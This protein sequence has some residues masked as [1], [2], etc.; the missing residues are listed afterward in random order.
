MATAKPV[1]PRIWKL[2]PAR[3]A[4][5]IVGRGRASGWWFNRAV[6]V[7]A[8]LL[9]LGGSRCDD[10]PSEIG[11]L[12]SQIRKLR[13]WRRNS[14]SASS[15]AATA[16]STGSATG[17]PRSANPDSNNDARSTGCRRVSRRTMSTSRSRQA[18]RR[19]E[20]TRRRATAWRP[21][22][23][24]QSSAP[25][26]A[27]PVPAPRSPEPERP[28]FAA[29]SSAMVDVATT[30]RRHGFGEPVGASGR[31]PPARSR[32]QSAVRPVRPSG[33]VAAVRLRLR[34]VCAAG[35]LRFRRPDVM[36]R[37]RRAD[38]SRDGGVPGAG[39]QGQHHG[40]R[41]AAAKGAR[42]P[43]RRRTGGLGGTS[44]GRRSRGGGDATNGPGRTAARFVVM[45]GCGGHV[46][47]V[48]RC[49]G[50]GHGER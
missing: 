16:D 4:T 35:L 40:V 17:R 5:R 33:R 19:G 24:R 13:A 43:A 41:D 20:V 38:Q 45:P 30:S 15:S 1:Y 10:H 6:S 50:R 3:P 12:A 29:S 27:R 32:R 9:S 28:T 46:I 44:T 36:V 34:T 8:L 37:V 31:P 21:W 18:C 11:V 26:R 39:L 2:G 7:M 48:P 22:R 23:C 25:A 14:A 49:G 42:S 47:A